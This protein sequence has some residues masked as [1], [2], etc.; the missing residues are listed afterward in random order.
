MISS[1][2]ALTI[3]LAIA[4]VLPI[5]VIVYRTHR[6]VDDP[7]PIPLGYLVDW[8]TRAQTRRYGPD[9]DRIIAE[10]DILARSDR[11]RN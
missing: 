7:R 3:V 4:I 10:L 5:A 2:T 11:T 9:T 6:R 1:M 8:A